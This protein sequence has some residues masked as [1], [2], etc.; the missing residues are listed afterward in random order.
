MKITFVCEKCGK[1][2]LFEWDYVDGEPVCTHCGH[3][4]RRTYN[5]RPDT[6]TLNQYIGLLKNLAQENG[7]LPV[8]VCHEFLSYDGKKMETK[9]RWKPAWIPFV[10]L[11][12]Q[13]VCI[14]TEAIEEEE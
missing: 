10:S 3:P 2:N 6:I 14:H 12:D 1:E 13:C 9:E 5:Y 4:Y 11:T 8:R 7:N